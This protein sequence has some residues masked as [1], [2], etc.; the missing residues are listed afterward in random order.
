MKILHVFDT[1][2]TA[3]ILGHYDPENT[4]VILQLKA[5]DNFGFGN[6]YEN[7][8]WFDDVA[9]LVGFAIESAEQYHKVIIHDHMLAAKSIEHDEK[10]AFWH[11]SALRDR[12]ERNDD[13]S[14][15]KVFYHDDDLITARPEGIQISIPIDTKLFHPLAEKGSGI[16]ISIKRRWEKQFRLAGWDKAFKLREFR[17]GEPYIQYEDMPKYLNQFAKYLDVRYDMKTGVKPVL[18]MSTTALQCLSMGI[19]VIDIDECEHTELP[20][21]HIASNVSKKF[22]SELL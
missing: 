15:K 1:A 5:L 13:I 11:G 21:K 6:Y 20:E 3:S 16:G 4:H 17:R 9:E 8:I 7:V 19:P 12:P 10:Y 22:I 2:G 14:C 18:S